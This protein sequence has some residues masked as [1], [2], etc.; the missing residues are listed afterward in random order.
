V[1][2]FSVRDLGKDVSGKGERADA[3][4]TFGMLD[5]SGGESAQSIVLRR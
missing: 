1:Q 4:N 5:L 3:P 2:W